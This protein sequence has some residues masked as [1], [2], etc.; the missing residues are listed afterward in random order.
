[1]GFEH[2]RFCRRNKQH[3]G[4]GIEFEFSQFNTHAH[5]W[6]GTCLFKLPPTLVNRLGNFGSKQHIRSRY[7][8]CHAWRTF[9]NQSPLTTCQ[10][11]V[12]TK[13]LFYPRLRESSSESKWQKHIFHGETIPS[14]F[15]PALQFSRR[16]PSIPNAMILDIEK[17]IWNI[18]S[19][20]ERRRKQH[21]GSKV[22]FDFTI[23]MLGIGPTPANLNTPLNSR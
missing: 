16:K 18:N 15:C 11:R 20:F 9:R 4:L 14:D 2:S 5:N 22:E 21:R 1:V 3:W 19:R 23:S 13:F 17:G 6:H 8:A 10:S 12:L 7:R